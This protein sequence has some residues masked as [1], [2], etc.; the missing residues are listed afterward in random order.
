[1]RSGHMPGAT[2]VPLSTLVAHNGELVAKSDIQ[3]A[4]KDIDPESPII[5]TCGSGV[6]AAGLSLS[7]HEIGLNSRVYDGSWSEWGR[8]TSD[9]AVITGDS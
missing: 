8:E 5:T 1:M 4:F 2:N 3:T 9:G 7:L 6:T